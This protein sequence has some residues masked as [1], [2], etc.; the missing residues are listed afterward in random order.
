MRALWVLA[1]VGLMFSLP[2]WAADEL[3]GSP[4]PAVWKEQRLDFSYMGRTARYSCEGLRDKMR[5]LLLDLGARR[6]LKVSLLG[7]NESAPLRQGYLGPRLSI[8]FSSPVLPDAAAKPL[9]PGDLSAVQARYE[10]FTLTSDA[11]RNYGVGDCELVEEF[12]RQIL[13]KFATKDV[14]QDIT[15]VPYQASGSR[16]FV[17]GEILRAGAIPKAASP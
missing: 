16:F 14:K 2:L 6:D 5:S 3:A 1:G 9:R 17:R 10:S 8:V 13:P 12:A 15:C 7:C 11:F 4:V